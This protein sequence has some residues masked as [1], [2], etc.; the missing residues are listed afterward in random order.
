MAESNTIL[1]SS[2]PPVKNKLKGT[3]P[4]IKIVLLKCYQIAKILLDGMY[5]ESIFTEYKEGVKCKKISL[6]LLSMKQDF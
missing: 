1:Q 4:Q 2:Y 3:D 5:F 6:M